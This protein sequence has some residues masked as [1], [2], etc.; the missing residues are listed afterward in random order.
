MPTVGVGASYSREANSENGK[1]AALGAPT[2]AKN[3]YQ[4]AF[5]AAWEIDLW[6][7]A[8]R[9]T[10]GANASL[11][12]TI[13]EQEGARVT[14]AAE[15]GRVYLQMRGTQAQIDVAEQ[16]L[17][18]AKRL[19]RLAESR[20]RNGIATRFETSSARAQAA[21]ISSLLPELSQRRHS[22]MNAL[23]LLLGQQPRTLDEQLQK[24]MPLP[25]L[26]R[27]VPV[28]LPSELA[29]RRP[30]ILRAEAQL[31]AATAAIGVAK[32]D[33]YPRVGLRGR[34]GVEAFEFGD[35]DNWNSRAFSFG[36][37]IYLPIFQGGRLTQRLKLNEAS[38]KSA[39][40]AYRKTV[41]NAWHEVDNALDA[42]GSQQR[43]HAELLVAVEQNREALRAA[44][45]G[46]EEGAADYLSVLA[47][48]RNLLT[49]QTNLNAS[50]TTGTLT[51]VNLYKSLGGGWNPANDY[52]HTPVVDSASVGLQ[53]SRP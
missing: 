17:V 35:V 14:L 15:V 49:S 8:R 27:N 51:L 41:L 42:W 7:R 6:G 19:V 37:T 34:V 24:S 47:A 4:L 1:F 52:T 9:A 44:E 36:P 11:Q 22:L 48:Q 25:S 29:R 10:E 50:A 13:Y 43:Q 5:D 28:G 39:A 45:R 40:I 38:Q 30:D 21:T 16:N 32:A 53:G 46:Y 26:P 31:H 3:F 20:E 33:F 23:A 18:V 12:S 2:D